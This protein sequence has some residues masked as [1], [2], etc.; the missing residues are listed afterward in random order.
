MFGDG[1]SNRNSFCSRYNYRPITEGAFKQG[2]GDYNRN[3]T[4]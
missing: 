1:A 3:L 2:V 4:A